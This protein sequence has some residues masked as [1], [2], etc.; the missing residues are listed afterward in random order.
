[1]FVHQHDVADRARETK[2]SR[3]GLTRLHCKNVTKRCVEKMSEM[4]CSGRRSKLKHRWSSEDLQTI[5]GHDPQRQP[6]RG[7]AG[8]EL[9]AKPRF[10]SIALAF[11]AP[12]LA[13]DSACDRVTQGA[14]SLQ[15][16]WICRNADR[17]ASSNLA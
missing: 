14:V 3:D 6:G 5:R 4:I 15:G 12:V 1:M 9:H 8:T 7:E 16:E 10:L 2:H 11:T 17:A 13:P